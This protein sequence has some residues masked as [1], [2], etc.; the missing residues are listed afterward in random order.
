MPFDHYFCIDNAWIELWLSFIFKNH[1]GNNPHP[2]P[3]NNR[4]LAKIL[5]PLETA[6]DTKPEFY[7]VSKPLY[8]FIW[9]LYGGG[10]S[11]I[12]NVIHDRCQLG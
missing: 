8:Y 6:K 12:D 4:R 10:P 11:I 5:L 3:I 1:S 7:I 2:G 9:S